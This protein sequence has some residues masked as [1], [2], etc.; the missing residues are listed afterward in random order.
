MQPR[1]EHFDHVADVGVRGIAPT[2][3]GAFEQAALA[4]VALMTDPGQ[5]QSIESR[6]IVCAAPDDE[7]LLIDWLNRLIFEMNTNDQ[8][9]GQFSVAITDD[10]L[11]ATIMGETIDYDRHQP[12][13]E[14]KGATFT[15]LE[16]GQREDGMWVAQCVIDV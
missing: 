16:V 13:V 1:W 12:M 7:F 15:A 5:I 11:H 3:A 6:E 4:L 2:R 8:I 14:P 10:T 9:Y